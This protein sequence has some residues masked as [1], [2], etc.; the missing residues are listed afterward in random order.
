[1]RVRVNMTRHPLSSHARRRDHAETRLHKGI[2]ALLNINCAAGII[3]FHPANEFDGTASQLAHRAAMGVVPG[4]PDLVFILP[5]GVA[6]FL[7]IKRP[8]DRV[9]GQAAGV[10]AS[11]QK[12]FIAAAE[13]L[14]CRT[15]IVCTIASAI[16]VLRAWQVLRRP[17]TVAA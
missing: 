10:L 8:C 11:D 17:V 5:G 4:V 16:E 1:M 2:V 3:W 13:A 14:G 6:A 12:A 7:E 9:R 15:A